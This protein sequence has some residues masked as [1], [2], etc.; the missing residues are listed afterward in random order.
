MDDATA[1]VENNLRLSAVSHSVGHGNE[2]K[3]IPFVDHPGTAACLCLD[4]AQE[5]ILLVE[6]YRPVIGASLLEIPSG[7]I[8]EGENPEE[9]AIRETG[10]ET[11]YT[12]SNLVMMGSF[13]SSVGLTTERLYLYLAK[14]AVKVG[15]GEEHIRA[16]WTSLREAIE[17]TRGGLISDAKSALAICLVEAF[18]AS[19]S[20]V[21]SAKS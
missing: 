18:L 8:Q 20:P 14:E 11:G 9:T 13:F 4:Q 17:M 12:P 10:E 5:R 3:V 1:T 6:Q 21:D 2:A 15:T 19:G 16:T 7:R